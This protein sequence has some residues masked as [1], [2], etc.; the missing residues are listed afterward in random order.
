LLAA[1]HPAAAAELVR[2]LLA[3]TVTSPAG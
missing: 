2:R 3:G 1:D